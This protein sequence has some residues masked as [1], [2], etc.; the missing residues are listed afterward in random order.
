MYLHIY[1]VYLKTEFL[2]T[3]PDIH[4]VGISTF[5]VAIFHMSSLLMFDIKSQ[6]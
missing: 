5:G 2:T 1:P 3:F 6:A 4:K